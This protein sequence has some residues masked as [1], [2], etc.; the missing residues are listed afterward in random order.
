MRSHRRA[1]TST[2]LE[3]SEPYALS[4]H[5]SLVRPNEKRAQ[6]RLGSMGGGATTRDTSKT[7]K[8]PVVRRGQSMTLRRPFPNVPRYSGKETENP[9][10][11]PLPSRDNAIWGSHRDEETFAK[12]RIFCVS[13]ET[14]RA[15]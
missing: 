15:Y 5:R 12:R 8:R 11:F 3:L 4:V 14:M 10:R 2:P 7:G 13:W 1:V 6:S 9:C